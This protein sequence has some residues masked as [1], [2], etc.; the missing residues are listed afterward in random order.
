[1]KKKMNFSIKSQIHDDIHTIEYL[2][3][4]NPLS[5]IKDLYIQ[6]AI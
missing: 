5:T 3:S 2:T 1:M 6:N 4:L